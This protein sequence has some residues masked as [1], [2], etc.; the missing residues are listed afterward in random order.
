MG[1][2]QELLQAVK[3]EDLLTV[4]RLLQRPKQGKS[5]LLGSAKRI[6]VNFQDTDG[7][8]AL[9]HAALNG[10]MELIAL[11]LESQAVVDIKD[12]KG[13][14]PLHYAAWQGKCEPMKMLLKAGSSV[15]SQSDEGQIPLHLSSQHGHYDGSEMLL[16][17]QSNPCIRDHA[18]K[19][20]LDLACE[21]GRVSVVQL[22]L[23]SNMCAAMLEPKPSDPNGIS[24]LHLAAKNGH[25]DIIKL[26][27]QAGIDINRQ[28]KS[29][30][31]LH[32][33]ALCGKTEAVRLL[34]D[35]GISAS[36]RN[37]YCQTALDIVNQF[38]TTQASREIKQMLRDASAAMQVRALKDYC[39]NYDL[40]SLNIKAGD[41]ITVLEQHSDGR[42]KGCIHDNRTGNDRV[43]YFPSNMVEVIK[44]AGPSTQQYLKIH[45]RPPAIGSVAMVNGDSHILSLPLT[46][47]PPPPSLI[48]SHQPL[49][50][51]FGYNTPT[52]SS[53]AFE[54][55][56]SRSEG[57]KRETGSRGSVSSPHGSPTLSGQQSSS[58]EEIWVLRKPLAGAGSTGS[59]TS[60]RSSVSGPVD[61]AN[62]HLASSP[63]P[64]P[65]TPTHSPGLNTH[66]VNVPGLHA[67]AEGVKLLATVLS[68]SA[69]AKEHLL[70][71]DTSAASSQLTQSTPG[72]PRPEK[73]K[74]F[75]DPL[76]QRKDSAATESKSSEAVA[77][78]LTSAQ[79][80]F[81]T[82]NFLT[83]GYDLQTIS[84]MTPEDLTAIGVTKP[85]HRKKMLSEIT[86]LSIPDWIP[87]EKP[88]SLAEWLSL[89][90][91]SQYYQTLVQN[92][93][94]NMD[95]VSDITLEDLQEI[96]I[97]KLGHQKKLMLA[98]NRLGEPPKEEDSYSKERQSDESTTSKHQDAPES[99]PAPRTR[100]GMEGRGSPRHTTQGR[101]IQR[102]NAPPP[103]KKPA[104]CNS[105]AH[106]PPHTP[107]KVKSSS[108][109]PNSQARSVPLLCLPQESAAEEDEDGTPPLPRRKDPP[110]P[111]S[112][113]K[114]ATVGGANRTVSSLDVGGVNRSQ[115]FATTRPR[116]KTR[117]PTPPKRSCSSISTGN[118]LNE[119][120]VNQGEPCDSFLSVT[121]RERR[122]SDCGPASESGVL[123]GSVRD[124]AAMLEMSTLGG[125]AKGASRN[126]LQASPDIL[127]RNRDALSSDEEIQSRRRTISGPI[128]DYENPIA[129][130]D[131]TQQGEVTKSPRITDEPV[132][133][134][135]VRRTPEPRPRSMLT[136]EE[137]SRMD[138]TATLRRPRAPH[139]LGGERFQLTETSTVRRRPKVIAPSQR[140]NVAANA[141]D[142]AICVRPVSEVENVYREGDMSDDFKR[143]LK[144]PV[145]PKPALGLRKPEPPTPTRR[146]PLPG[147]ENQHSTAEVKKVPPPVSPKPSPPPTLPKPIKM[148]PLPTHTLTPPSDLNTHPHSSTVLPEQVEHP[149]LSPSTQTQKPAESH[150]LSP[151]P[152]TSP[153]QSPQT[154]QTPST[155]GC[156]S[157]P[158]KPPRSSMAGLSV[159][160]PSPFEAEPREVEKHNEDDEQKRQRKEVAVVRGQEM[161]T[162]NEVTKVTEGSGQA[163]I[164]RRKVGVA[165]QMPIEGEIE[166]TTEDGGVTAEEIRQGAPNARGS[167]E[168]RLHGEEEINQLRLD[169]TSASLAAALEVVE[170]RIMTEDN[171]AMENKSTVNILDDIGSMF[172]DLADQLEAMLD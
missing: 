12:Q 10:N 60:G 94:D 103:L 7:F 38:T 50:T 115:S 147:P 8:S 117:P 5:K 146:V 157:A 43:G 126:Y 165:R 168:A 65:T 61:N 96:G 42:W 66:G 88:T 171:S 75:V 35:S 30:T 78:W 163:L 114:Y 56:S 123:G 99:T 138:A 21:F 47:L 85:G 31:A 13:M 169:E 97:T 19:T 116:R 70:E 86:K 142:A 52:C 25:I 100:R 17:H 39:N 162:S 26:L 122:R 68:Q 73:K 53:F 98:V 125:R 59:L 139:D 91:L 54:P 166:S 154:P 172:D 150:T 81:Y 63:V 134:L 107:T 74:T 161:G 45:I 72:G 118:L 18:G 128:S 136:Q 113:M 34:L 109:R 11:L 64:I 132:E 48:S 84:R 155:P 89:I 4:Q 108:P 44:R 160:I 159:D 37:T 124:I 141:P 32:E 14:R 71:Q 3:T 87:K 82:T 27:I 110:F 28:T 16:Q 119:G 151:R 29:G 55:P 58:S 9:H 76:L 80:Q 20:P 137:W 131:G 2:D 106:T 33:A 101:G 23:N 129:Q 152:L 149:V 148:K 153:A 143:A 158:V 170:E 24:P 92:G 69:K 167:D 57:P 144:P 111:D 1:K 164:R 105:P 112:S 140:D 95:F 127:R 130:Q 156:G 46:S 133:A 40:T 120:G 62:A 83:A 49:F 41:I 15:N 145:S 6:N 104:S 93:Y 90:G 36:V 135:P 121:Y 102:A 22:L 79:L 77:E 51:S 67:Q